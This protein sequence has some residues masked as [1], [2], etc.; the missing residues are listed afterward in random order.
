MIGSDAKGTMNRAVSALKRTYE[1]AVFPELDAAR[2]ALGAKVDAKLGHLKVGS[3]LIALPTQ[4]LRVAKNTSL[5][6]A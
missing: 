5:R 4:L 3:E 6:R 2:S 1:T